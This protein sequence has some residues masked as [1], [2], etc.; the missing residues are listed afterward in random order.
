[1]SSPASAWRSA[2]HGG[3]TRSASSR[4]WPTPCCSRGR[5]NTSDQTM[6]LRWSPGCCA[7][8]WAGNEKPVHR[9]R[10]TVGERI[11]RVLQRKTQGRMPQWRD[12]LQPEGGT[13][14]HRKLACPLQHKAPALR[15]RLSTTGA[16][17]GHATARPDARHQLTSHSAWY[18][19]SVRPLLLLQQAALAEDA[20]Q[21]PS[22]I[23][24]F[25]TGARYLWQGLPSMPSISIPPISM[26]GMPDF[27]MPDLMKEFDAFTQQVSD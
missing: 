7:S 24:N 17:D 11:L 3:S 9:T 12:L 5:L 14:R 8:G 10:L 21:P 26:P 23:D 4:P 18:K 1:M 2:S 20:Q 22:N 19:I 6:A 16:V 27:S 13:D 15:A 25:K